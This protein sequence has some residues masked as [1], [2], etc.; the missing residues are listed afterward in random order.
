VVIIVSD[1]D[2]LNNEDPINERL[3]LHAHGVT[4]FTV[5]VGVWLKETIMRNL[6]TAWENYANIADWL[7][8]LDTQPT[9]LQPGNYIHLEVYVGGLGRLADWHLPGGPVGPAAWWA[10]TSNVGVERRTWPGDA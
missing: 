7:N 8:L 6:A 1:G 10:V 2:H 5:G 4:I 9:T 3:D